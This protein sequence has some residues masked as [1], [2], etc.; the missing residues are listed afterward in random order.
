MM[1]A[2]EVKKDIYWVGSL[3]PELRV[4]DVIMYTPYGTTYNSYVVKGSEKTAI[5][6]TVKEKTFDQY[7]ERLKS[8][9]VN[10][11]E[12]AY[13]IVQHTEPDH[14]G[15]VAKLLDYAKNAK[16][17][18]SAPAIRFLRQIANRPFQEVIVKQGDSLSLGDKTLRFIEAPFLH[19]PDSI[20]TYVEEDKALMTCDSFGSHYCFD[21]MFRDLIPEDKEKEYMDALKYYYDCIMGPF[22]PYVIKALDKIKDFD[23]D[24][25]CTGHG[26]ILRGNVD[27]YRDLYRTWSTEIA[28]SDGLTRVVIPYVSA[29]GFTEDL[30][31]SISK[32][33]KSQID[34]CLIDMYNVIEHKQEVILD[35]IYWADAVLFGSPTI[36]GDALE[37]IMELLIKMNPL[38]H[39]GKIAAA[40]GSF[41]WSGEAVPNMEARLKALRMKLVTPGLK[42]NFKPN[43]EEL[44]KAYKFGETIAE[45]IKENINKGVRNLRKSN[46]KIWR[47]IVC[48]EEF[49]S[50]KAPEI[51]PAC[52]ATQD[53]FIEVKKEEVEFKQSKKEKYLIIGNGISGYNAAD[54]IRKRNAEAD[55]H[56]LSSE[57]VLTYYRPQ[58]SDYISKDIADK[59]FFVSP[60]EWYDKNNI[61]VTLGVRVEKINKDNSIVTLDNGSELSYDKLILATGASNFLPPIKGFEK[62]GVYVL[63]DVEDAT[64]IKEKMKQAKNA[65]IVG[66]GLL[67]LEAA[68]EMKN[69]GMNVTV[70][71]LVPHLLSMQLDEDGSMLFEKIVAEAGVTALIGEGAEEVLGDGTVTGLKLK[72]GKLIDADLILFSVGIRPNLN[73]AKEAGL[74]VNRGIL[75]NEKMETSIASI[76]ACGDNAELN[77]RI[78]GNW[79]A[80]SEMG[81]VA[82][83]NASGEEAAF[84][85]FVSSVVF[86]AINSQIFS[87]GDV[88]PAGANVEVL[89]SI[90]TEKR[91]YKKLFF[92][93]KK[94]VGG[95][96]IGDTKRS[97]RLMKAVQAGKT[98]ADVLKEEILM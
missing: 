28:P 17:V 53:Q 46:L 74:A 34:D 24:T 3:D 16:V 72:S 54:S 25:I 10:F 83:A 57:K 96:L 49:E 27:F 12:I 47:C 91:V 36:N 45:K 81:K 67:G 82:G 19:W 68:W 9:N 78:Y 39:G 21:E 66:G 35:K 56:M 48:G 30:A 2:L 80:A 63:R 13:I 22:K 20:Y 71:E 61:K 29:Y 94:L 40:F 64:K 77:G 23:I 15:S 51:C 31:K 7:L 62:Q 37:P 5:F 60:E 1:K 6:E 84:K 93:D 41:G 43:E 44:L 8:I 75:V 42:I 26:P 33:I 95:I 76:Y 89:S 52:G 90:N 58:L 11:D 38:V 18:G 79:P 70:V 92:K 88:K 73:L 98:M 86:N 55:I 14:A 85:D 65:V 32:G 69:A 4:F 87:V 97:V 59:R 50:D